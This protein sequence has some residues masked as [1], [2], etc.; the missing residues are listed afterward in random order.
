MTVR[1]VYCYIDKKWLRGV[2]QE[3][4]L[5]EQHQ[6]ERCLREERFAKL[7]C[8]TAGMYTP[9]SVLMLFCVRSIAKRILIQPHQLVALVLILSAVTRKEGEVRV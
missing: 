8:A 9:E 4:Y 1:T 5:R 2:T 6:S 7:R 3:Q